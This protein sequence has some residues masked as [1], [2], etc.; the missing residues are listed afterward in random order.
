MGIKRE[1]VCVSLCKRERE[2]ERESRERES[3]ERE[4]RDL[5]RDFEPIPLFFFLPFFFTDP[6]IQHTHTHTHTY[7][8]M[9]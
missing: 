8:H 7:T 6:N 9:H 2:R 3:R 1:S 5:L 4:Q